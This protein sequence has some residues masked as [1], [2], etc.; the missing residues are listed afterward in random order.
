MGGGGRGGG[1]GEWGEFGEE[2]DVCG[3]G[4]LG[5]ALFFVFILL[6]LFVFV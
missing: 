1:G 3:V 2:V 6:C 4:D 5:L